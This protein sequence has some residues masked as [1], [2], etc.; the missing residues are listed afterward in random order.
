MDASVAKPARMPAVQRR[1]QLLDMTKEIV[2]ENG[3]H[4][5]SIEA[6]ARR[7][8]ISRPIVYEHFGDL[9]GLLQALIGR[10]GARALAQHAGV[11]PPDLAGGDR[12]EQLL[13]GRRGDVE[14][15]GADP[16]AW[17]LV[18]MPQ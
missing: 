7:A 14:A 15:R 6:V 8:G 12:A 4:A 17:R 3:F 5:V 10:D 18:L 11:L 9:A 1:E 13:T 16:V 2:A